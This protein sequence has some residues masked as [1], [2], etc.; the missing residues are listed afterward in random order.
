MATRLTLDDHLT[1]LRHSGKTLRESAATAGLEAKVPTCPSWTVSKLVSHQGMVH[2]WAAANLRRERDHD[3][4]ASLAAAAEAPD[5][6]EWYSEG[7]DALLDTIAATA[8]DAEA[9]VFLNDAPPAR[10]FWARRQ[11]HETTIHAVDGVAAA[12]GRW[13]TAA[14]V[15]IDP[16]LAADGIDEILTGFLTRGKSRLSAPEPYTLVVRADDTGDAWTLRVGDDAIATAVGDTGTADAVISGA[17]V[18]VYLGLWNRTEELVATG[19]ADLAA[20][21]RAQIRIRW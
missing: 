20:E 12:L 10:R 18:E 14:D 13:P 8:D 6:L 17:A 5:L 16:V 7:L 11:A 15:T 9:Y 1:A 19:R 4:E 3:T 2:R 21:W